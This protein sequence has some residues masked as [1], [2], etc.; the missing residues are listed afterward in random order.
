MAKKEV[1]G[2]ISLQVKSE[3]A[4]PSPPIG[5]ALGQK[6]LNIME[7]CKRFNA[8]KFNYP[9]GTP[10]PVKIFAYKDKTFD[11]ETKQPPISFLIMSA[12]GI[13]KG[14]RNPS[15]EVAGKLTL[16]MIDKIVELKKPDLNT[17]DLFACRKMVV[18]SARSMGIEC[19]EIK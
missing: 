16:E 9:K 5:P 17:G 15:K 14:A 6:G 4:N 18:G 13:Q 1:I 19:E 12:L 8:L 7:F 10:I 11:F 3:S 2:I